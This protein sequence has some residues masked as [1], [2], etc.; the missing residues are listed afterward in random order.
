MFVLVA[1]LSFVFS[2][3]FALGGVGSAIALVPI[4]NWIGFPLNQVKPT[5]LFINTL[6][7]V[8]AT[9]SNIKEKRVNFKIG[10]PIIITSMVIAPLG[11]Y[12]S[13][14]VPTK[15]VLTVFLMF[16]VFAGSMLIFY[17]GSKRQTFRTDAPYLILSLIGG[18]AGFISGLLGVGG[19]TLISPLMVFMGYNPKTVAAI[20]ALVVPFSSFTG[21][22]SYWIMGH[23]NPALLVVAGITAYL[24]GYLGTY[25]MQKKLKPSTVKRFLGIIVFLLAIKLF[26]KLIK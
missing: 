5:C 10:L 26:F 19:G 8:G 14:K 11:A 15:A 12:I 23:V 25:F 22:I 7:M 4:L 18:F 24:G 1:V 9:I 21:F 17:R 13:T 6:S 2:F 3:I 16:L 20:T